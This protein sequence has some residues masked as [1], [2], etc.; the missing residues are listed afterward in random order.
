[1]HRLTLNILVDEKAESTKSH[2]VTIA[3]KANYKKETL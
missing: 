1:M 3:M 2:A